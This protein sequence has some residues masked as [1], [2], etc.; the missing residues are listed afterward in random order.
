MQARRRARTGRRGRPARFEGES[1]RRAALSLV[2][3]SAVYPH[4]YVRLGWADGHPDE[5]PAADQL[6]G[7]AVARG[8]GRHHAVDVVRRE[9]R[10][11]FV[12]AD[13]STIRELA[14]VPSGNSD[15]QS[16]A[17]ATVPAGGSTFE[18]Y[19]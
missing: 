3:V 8:G 5:R 7:W 2:T 9:D 1:P 13:G 6:R 14:G 17:E 18:H 10:E 19:H 4:S 15:N 16:L 11:P 12:T